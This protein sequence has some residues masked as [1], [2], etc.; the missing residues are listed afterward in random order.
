MN[1]GEGYVEKEDVRKRTRSD[2]LL[3]VGLP[4]LTGFLFV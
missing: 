4:T 3:S 2:R 1:D